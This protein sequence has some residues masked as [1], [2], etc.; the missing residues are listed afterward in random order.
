MYVFEVDFPKYRLCAEM[1]RLSSYWRWPGSALQLSGALCLSCH[2]EW[3]S[4][5][6][7]WEPRCSHSLLCLSGR[8][9]TWSTVHQCRSRSTTWSTVLM[10]D[11]HICPASSQD[12][13]PKTAGLESCQGL[14]PRLQRF[15]YMEWELS[16]SFWGGRGLVTLAYP[17]IPFWLNGKK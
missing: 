11:K 8:S 10:C 14:L 15:F 12:S 4:W 13:I 1:G 9:T 2:H 5:S 3:C 7:A 17:I 16:F 6:E